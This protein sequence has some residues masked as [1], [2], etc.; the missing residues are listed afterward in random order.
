M[1]VKLIAFKSIGVDHAELAAPTLFLAEKCIGN[2][3]HIVAAVAIEDMPC[4]RPSKA[5]CKGKTATSCRKRRKM[6]CLH[7]GQLYT[8]HKRYSSGVS[9][10]IKDYFLRESTCKLPLRAIKEY[11]AAILD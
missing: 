3:D 8:M 1:I 9:R 7:N 4:R 6:Y 10:R 2:P 5:L 11:M